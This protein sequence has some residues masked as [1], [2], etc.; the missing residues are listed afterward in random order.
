MKIK[1]LTFNKFSD[2]DLNHN[3]YMI[4]ITKKID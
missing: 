1:D 2:I 4:Q 3:Y